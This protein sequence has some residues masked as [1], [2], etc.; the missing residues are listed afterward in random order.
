[1]NPELLVPGEFGQAEALIRQILP[2]T[3]PR[4]GAWAGRTIEAL[5]EEEQ[6]AS[7]YRDL[8][9]Y[10]DG[11]VCFE[12]PRSNAAER[13]SAYLWL[14]EALKEQR[15]VDY[16]IRYANAMKDPETGIYQGPEEE[17]RGGVW[18]WRDVGLYMTNYTFRVPPAFLALAEKTRNAGYREAALQAGEFLLRMQQPTGIFREGWLPRQ[19]GTRFPIHSDSIRNYLSPTKINSRVG[20]VVE[21]LVDLAGCTGDNRYIAALERFC[22]GF[23]KFQYPDGSFPGDIRVDVEEIFS[24][25]A[26]GHFLH[27]IMNGFGYAAWRMPDHSLIRSIAVKLADYLVAQF[28]QMGAVY[29]GNPFEPPLPGDED[30]WHTAQPGGI[31]G[32]LYLGRCEDNPVYREVACR[33]ILQGLLSLA[34]TPEQPDVHGG[35]IWWGRTGTRRPWHIDG[36][37]HFSLILGLRALAA[38]SS[39]ELLPE[40][41]DHAK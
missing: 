40:C 30:S 24:R 10:S 19:P 25:P 32:L 4:L 28:R 11:R 22:D 41:L 23:A 18:Y 38:T 9:C 2:S 31:P 39:D 8:S 15:Y 36:Y 20:Q 14:E 35:L 12:Y 13:I 21:A 6:P 27:Y 26:K 33:L 34:D 17:G 5:P 16:A 37:Y 7:G 3:L 1:M 29:F